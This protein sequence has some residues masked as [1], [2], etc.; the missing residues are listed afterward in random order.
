[1][2]EIYLPVLSHFENDN[3]WTAS[4]DRMRYKVVPEEENLVAEVWEGPWEYA[5]ST[6]EEKQYFP[7]SED[8][9]VQL[10]RWAGSW[11]EQM[12]ARPARTLEETIAMRD[13]V[14]TR[15]KEEA[16]KNEAE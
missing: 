16:Q 13:A 7:M 15:K 12:N 3:F 10:A 4:V 8:G 2:E 1:M 6:V 11:A 5:F 14:M 9:L